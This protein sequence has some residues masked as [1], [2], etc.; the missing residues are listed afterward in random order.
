MQIKYS[1]LKGGGVFLGNKF[2]FKAQS[3]CLSTHANIE[4]IKKREKE[5][6]ILSNKI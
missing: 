6:H 2:S 4:Y 1:T 3:A 5:I